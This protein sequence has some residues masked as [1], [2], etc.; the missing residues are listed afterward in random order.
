MTAS[1][2][3]VS[4]EICVAGGTNVQ[5][6]YDV[7]QLKWCPSVVLSI[8][9]DYGPPSLLLAVYQSQ[10]FTPIVFALNVAAGLTNY[11]DSKDSSGNG[12]TDDERARTRGSDRRRSPASRPSS[13]TTTTGTNVDTNGVVVSDGSTIPV[14][15]PLHQWNGWQQLPSYYPVY[16]Q[17]SADTMYVLPGERRGPLKP[18]E[19][20]R[21]HDH[22][23]QHFTPS[24]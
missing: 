4:Y 23:L 14:P 22:V 15:L 3:R 2:E 21:V 19:Y 17:S 10:G 16:M 6:R 7:P 11:T 9:A 24:S 1:A 18:D 8:I 5:L 12:P 13:S 20:N